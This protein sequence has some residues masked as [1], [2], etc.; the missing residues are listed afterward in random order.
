MDTQT[1]DT[2]KRRL[3]SISS[4][5]AGIERMIDQEAYCIDVIK[6]VAA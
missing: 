1:K 4:H 6:Q 3:K 2:L 5:V